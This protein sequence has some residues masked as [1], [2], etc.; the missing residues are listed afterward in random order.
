MTQTKITLAGKEIQMAY[1]FAT[2]ITFR[3]YTGI[4]IEDSEHTNP[5]H[6]VYTILSGILA[7][8]KGN[9]LEVPIKD[10][11]IIYQAE[12][13]ELVTAYNEFLRIRKEWYNVPETDKEKEEGDPKNE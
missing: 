2:E 1:C 3:N 7:Y 9:G 10:T 12:P 13:A 4:N 5:E 11:D 8:Y 6:V